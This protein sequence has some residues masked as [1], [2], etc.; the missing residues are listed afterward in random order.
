MKSLH[1][2]LVLAAVGAV[3]LASPAFAQRPHHEASHQVRT[4]TEYPAP[5]ANSYPN[6]QTHSGSVQSRDSG[7]DTIGG[8]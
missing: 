6:P 8:D 1:T 2:K 4:Q 3:L 7:N 5:A